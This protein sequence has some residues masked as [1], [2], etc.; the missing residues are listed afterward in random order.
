MYNERMVN[1]E[2][3]CSERMC[4]PELKLERTGLSLL[5]CIYGDGKRYI[6]QAVVFIKSCLAFRVCITYF[7]RGQLVRA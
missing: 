7:R 1:V 6:F 3:A 5:E 2:R 4:A